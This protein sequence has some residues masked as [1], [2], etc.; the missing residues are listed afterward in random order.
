MTALVCNLLDNAV[1]ATESQEEAFIEF[2]IYPKE[3]TPFTVLTLT[4]SC[5]TNP[6]SKETGTLITHKEDKRM[7]GFGM[8]SV[9]KIVG[10]YNGD[11]QSYYSEEDCTFH[12][13]LTIK[14][15]S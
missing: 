3:N 13:I 2:C 5:L 10:K 9:Q 7:H 6:F 8:K 14:S 15:N 12:T 4:N 1:E 11:M